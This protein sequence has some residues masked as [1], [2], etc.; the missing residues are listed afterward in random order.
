MAIFDSIIDGISSLGDWIDKQAK[1]V[2][3]GD[4]T[5]LGKD[6]LRS[7]SV[8]DKQG[9]ENANYANN[10]IMKYAALRDTRNKFKAT[11]TSQDYGLKNYAPDPAALESHW[12]QVLQKFVDTSETGAVSYKR[13]TAW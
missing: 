1:D 13:T 3:F 11:D 5:S 6:A 10:N 8:L 12:G 9:K 4:L 2:S 7:Y